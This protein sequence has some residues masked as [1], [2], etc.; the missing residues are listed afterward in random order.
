MLSWTVVVHL[1][2][3][4]GSQTLSHLEARRPQ[5]NN[6]YFS[7]LPNCISLVFSNI[8]LLLSFTNYHLIMKGKQLYKIQQKKMII[9]FQLF[10]LTGKAS[11]VYSSAC[12]LSMHACSSEYSL[13]KSTA[14]HIFVFCSLQPCIPSYSST[15]LPILG[16]RRAHANQK[17]KALSSSPSAAKTDEIPFMHV[18]LA[19]VRNV[20]TLR[21]MLFFEAERAEGRSS[22]RVSVLPKRTSVRD[23]V[24]TCIAICISNLV[25]TYLSVCASVFLPKRTS[26]NATCC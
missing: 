11:Q 3:L 23:P 9:S 1:H 7:A 5:R 10:S 2:P 15:R 19:V 20:S 21:F 14:C 22:L 24:T 17:Y 18:L 16:E 13:A 4:S 25:P 6:L 12:K 26:V 8:S